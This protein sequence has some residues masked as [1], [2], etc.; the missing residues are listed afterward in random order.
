MNSTFAVFQGKNLRLSTGKCLED[1]SE[2]TNFAKRVIRILFW[3][4][5]GKFQNFPQNFLA[6]LSWRPPT[7]PKNESRKKNW[8][9]TV[10][11]F[12]RTP[13]KPFW[14]LCDD[15]F[16]GLTNMHFTRPK[17]VFGRN[18]C[19]KSLLHIHGFQAIKGAGFLHKTFR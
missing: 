15:F 16:A 17:W 4:W 5:D 12:S 3:L 11:C 18:L 1:I 13:R 6:E 9:Y 8:K 2:R 14:T 10:L 19:L 7:Y